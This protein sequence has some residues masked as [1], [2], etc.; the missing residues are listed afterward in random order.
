MKGV[1][2][3]NFFCVCMCVG[4]VDKSQTLCDMT[5]SRVDTK[6]LGKE[7]HHDQCSTNA[8]FIGG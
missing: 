4:A 8:D 1:E 6:G 7:T 3:A 5:A 2:I